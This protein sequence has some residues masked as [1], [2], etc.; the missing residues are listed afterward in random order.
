[1][2]VENQGFCDAQEW[3]QEICQPFECKQSNFMGCDS[4]STC[5]Q[6]QQQQQQGLWKGGEGRWV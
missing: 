1:M 2:V 5:E 4:T 3:V 6:Q